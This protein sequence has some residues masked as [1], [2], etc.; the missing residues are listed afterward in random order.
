MKSALAIGRINA[1]LVLS[2]HRLSLFPSSGM[3]RASIISAQY[4]YTQIPE[5]RTTFG[6][7]TPLTVPHV[8][9][10]MTDEIFVHKHDVPT[11]H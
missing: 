4:I 10:P 11:Q 6:H 3:D 5:E 9:R 2:L 1:H 7:L 8:V